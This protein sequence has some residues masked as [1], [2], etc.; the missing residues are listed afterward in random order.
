MANKRISALDDISLVG[1]TSTPGL[2]TSDIIPVTDVDDTTGSLQGTTKKVT[3]ADLLSGYQAEPAEGAFV[4]G[5]K[6]KLDGIEA[7]ADVTD[8][9]NV[10]AAGAL[11]DSEVTNLAQVKAFDS[12]D[13]ATAA[14]GSLADTATQPSDLGT[15]ATQDVG[16][17][18][19]NV[20][21]LDATGLPAVDGSQLTNVSGTDSSKLAIASNLSDLNDAATARAN[22][23]LGT[24]ATSASTDF[25]SA[26]Y[27]TVSQT[28]TSRTLSDSD[29]GKVIVCT[30][31]STITVTIPS[32]LTAGFS[33]KLVQGGAGII[34]VSAGSGTTLSLIGGKAFTSGQYQVVDLINYA[35]NAYVLDSNSLQTDPA[36]WSGN[37][38]SISLDG[39]TDYAAF[40]QTD[41]TSTTRSWSFWYKFSSTPNDIIPFIGGSYNNYFGLNP[42]NG[43]FYIN[44]GAGTRYA[45]GSTPGTTDWHNFIVTDNGAGTINMYLDGSSLT[46]QGSSSQ[47]TYTLNAIGRGD[48][49][50]VKYFPGNID[51]V[52]YF[53]STLSSPQVTN[54][55]KGESD[56]GS[57]GTNRTAG[58]LSTFS[59]EH[60]WR[61]G[62]FEGGTGSSV[63]DQGGASS[64]LD[65]TLSGAS[66]ASDAP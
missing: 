7:S 8:A 2:T 50:T 5:D 22:L 9:T 60:W 27:S 34:G 37:T 64:T 54:I 48:L 28:T 12:S 26:F 6:T 18:N 52:A 61:M 39:V 14:Q 58:D 45:L 20:V 30:N 13:Y 41:F 21:Q 57:G 40:T 59:P 36:A 65:L 62:D 47:G 35:T 4:D 1:G 23:G 49:G 42:S 10:T 66:F 16:T 24:A 55:Y 46:V 31:A 44:S 56:G 38:Y 53:T 25:S 19:G 32:T 43:Y 29:N 17:A 51:E 3:V 63:T 33:C 11:M 15:A